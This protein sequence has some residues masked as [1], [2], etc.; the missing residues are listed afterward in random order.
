MVWKPGELQSVYNELS[1]HVELASPCTN[2]LKFC[3]LIFQYTVECFGE[4]TLLDDC[5]IIPKMHC[6]H[7]AQVCIHTNKKIAQRRWPSLQTMI[8]FGLYNFLL[9][10][11][12][13]SDQHAWRN[14][15]GHKNVKGYD[16]SETSEQSALCVKTVDVENSILM[17]RWSIV[18]NF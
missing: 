9:H 11:R 3:L 15:R 17:Y 14:M 18:R 2:L 1:F 8:D 6:L 13:Y 16:T 12:S 4:A 7:H 5:L 10:R